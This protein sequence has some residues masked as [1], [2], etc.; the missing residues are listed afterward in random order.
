MSP[1]QLK[2]SLVVWLPSRQ[3][4]VEIEHKPKAATV[5]RGRLLSFVI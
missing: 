3:T 1:E 2:K 4:R 5:V